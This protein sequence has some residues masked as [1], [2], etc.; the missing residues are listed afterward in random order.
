VT[1]G[2][3]AR[4]VVQAWLGTRVVMAAVAVWVAVSQQLPLDEVFDRWDVVHFLTIA[5]EGYSQPRLIAFFPGWPMLI[6]V[7]SMLPGSSALAIGTLLALLA[8]AAATAALYRMY[9]TPAAVAWLLAPTAV[10]TM[11]PYSESV[12]CAAAFWAWERAQNKHWAAASVLTAVAATTRV[13]GLFLIVA[14]A[15]LALSQTGRPHVR[16]KR[17]LWLILPLAALGGYLLYL[18][19]SIGTWTAWYDAQAAGWSREFTWPWVSLQHTL[20][21]ASPST[22]YPANWS[23]MFRFEL[24]SMGVGV[25]V[26]VI[27]LF[28]KRWAEAVWIGSQ[29]AAFSTSYWFMSVNRAVLLW[30]P[31]WDLVGKAAVGRSKPPAWRSALIG[32]LI[33][34]AVAMQ[35]WWAYQF[36][37]GA[38]SS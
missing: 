17:L 2:K 12:F 30:F 6:S 38:W 10:F 22:T 9:G 25:V 26:T 7:S 34:G 18:R 37:T 28:R 33:V 14:L 1:M 19:F 31:A 21:I 32:V 24:V 23:L 20:D 8:S 11:V 27:S 3:N 13:S 16:L 35:S 29:V 36:F 5:T 15:V 4:L